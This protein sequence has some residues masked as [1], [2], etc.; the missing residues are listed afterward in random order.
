MDLGMNVRWRGVRVLIV[1][2]G[3]YPPNGGGELS[4]LAI[5]THLQFSGASVAVFHHGAAQV[6]GFETHVLPEPVRGLGIWTAQVLNHG[7]WKRRVARHLAQSQPDL[8]ITQQETS[9]A[10]VEAA[11]MEGIRSIVMIRGTDF[12]DFPAYGNPGAWRH[13][14]QA[15]AFLE[16]RRRYLRSLRQADAIIANSE[17]IRRVYEPL[18]GR[19][20]D[21]V[22]PAIDTCTAKVNHIGGHFVMLTP[23]AHKGGR[24]LLEMARRMPETKFVVAGNGEREIVEPLRALPNV[25]YLGW[26]PEPERLFDGAC[27]TL[28]PTQMRE[29]FGRVAVESMAHGVPVIASDCGGLPEALGNAGVLV[30]DRNRAA[31]WIQAARAL[32]ADPARYK[33]LSADSI[34]QAGT[35]EA[36]TQLR[37][38]DAVMQRTLEKPRRARVSIAGVPVDPVT[39][40]QACREIERACISGCRISVTTVNSEFI[41]QSLRD[42][43]FRNALCRSSLAVPDS[44]GITVALALRGLRMSR[45]PG[46][47]LTERLAASSAASG[48]RLF[49]LGSTAEVLQAAVR[50]LRLRYPEISIGTHAP[51]FGDLDGEETETMIEAVNDFAPDVL[52][53]A[54]GAPRQDVWIASNLS[55][56][57]IHAAIG[58]G[59]SFDMISGRLARCPA[60]AG[61]FGLEWAYRLMLEPTRW[62]RCLRVARFVPLALR[63]GKAELKEEKA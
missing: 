32:V 51:S 20:A 57:R 61:H 38:F 43:V 52:F 2:R 28:I 13:Y 36:A 50:R 9:A 30:A 7:Q 24:V 49:F 25:D 12:L 53:V 33:K 35:F 5:A 22:Y 44:F 58:V 31:T 39:L 48:L 27:V 54:L 3:L 6:P 10:V 46:V 34:V 63:T 59:G 26:T 23:H 17:F 11:R 15:P 16:A 4:L 8:V 47:E 14:L 56:L 60:L 21:V 41:V 40:P 62:R 55:R 29:A 19:N 1:S 37:A 45:C 42:N 18:A